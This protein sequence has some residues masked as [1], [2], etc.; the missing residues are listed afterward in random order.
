MSTP[1]PPEQANCANVTLGSPLANPKGGKSCAILPAIRLTLQDATTP[2]AV[3]SY[4]GASSRK[5]F[6]LRSTPQ[7]RAFCE[8]LDA[9]LRP[10]AKQLG[11]K[12]YTSLLKATAGGL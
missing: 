12:E 8:C 3:S 10:M 5:S 2:F 1:C 11:C 9:K 4:D 7:L 6:D